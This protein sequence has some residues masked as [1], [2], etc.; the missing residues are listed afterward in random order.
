[1]SWFE[2][3]VSEVKATRARLDALEKRERE[4][5]QALL[6]YIRADLHAIWMESA[7]RLETLLE[8]RLK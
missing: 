1:L 8:D 5:A 4:L 3:A 2:P 6:D 7:K